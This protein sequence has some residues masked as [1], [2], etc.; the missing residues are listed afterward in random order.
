M[1]TP[2]EKEIV[3]V[4][5]D[6]WK[7]YL[8]DRK[9]LKLVEPLFDIWSELNMKN[10]SLPKDHYIKHREIFSLLENVFRNILLRPYIPAY[11]TINMNSG[12]YCSFADGFEKKIFKQFGFTY[13]SENL[14]TYQ[15][16]DAEKTVLYAITSYIFW[17]VLTMKF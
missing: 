7:K 10:R 14:L 6:V 15:E 11:R 5:D 17:R 13:N 4:D 16:V 12:R 8:S 2:L 3:Y 9:K 1:L